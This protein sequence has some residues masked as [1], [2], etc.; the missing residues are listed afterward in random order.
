MREVVRKG[1]RGALLGFGSAGIVLVAS[2]C[3]VKR[4]ENTSLIEGKKLFVEKCGSCHTLAR[5]GTKGIIGPNL[6]I[7]F[8]NALQV[9]ERRSSIESVV[10][11][12]VKFPNPG[13]AM[14]ANI[15]K[16][17]QEIDDVAAYVSYAADRPGQDTGLLATAVAPA[18]AATEA[19]KNGALTIDANPTGLLAYTVKTATATPGPV[20]I[21]M[22]NAAPIQ[23]N[24][25]IQSGN[26]GAS[27]GSTPII[28]ATPILSTGGTAT[29][30]VTLKA[31][32]Y[33]FFCQVPG[34]R[35]AGMW[36]TI[37]VK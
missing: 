5:A 16:N 25:A 30:H 22:H 18:T 19:E 27:T 2:A 32:V 26:S 3:D 8:A 20:T 13:G 1:L 11:Y 24:I 6:D 34:H 36:G 14:P 33:T 10:H 15:I 35:A 7:A 23:H 37:T 4:Y 9:G 17:D 29:L 31:G 12:Q 21:T 28:A